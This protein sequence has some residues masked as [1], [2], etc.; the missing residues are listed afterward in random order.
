VAQVTI[1]QQQK[2]EV[3]LISIAATY[4]ALGVNV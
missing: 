1:S 3:E 4:E 2:P